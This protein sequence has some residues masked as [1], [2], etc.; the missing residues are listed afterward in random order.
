[1]QLLNTIYQIQKL[2]DINRFDRPMGWHR[3]IILNTRMAKY[4]VTTTVISTFKS[5]LGGN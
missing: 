4:V 2:S 5:K 1:M 3:H